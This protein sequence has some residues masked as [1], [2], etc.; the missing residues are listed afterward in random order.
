MPN[1]AGRGRSPGGGG[2]A[3]SRQYRQLSEL[4]DTR[5]SLFWMPM[6]GTG[7]ELWCQSSYKFL[8]GRREDYPNPQQMLGVKSI[9][10]QTGRRAHHKTTPIGL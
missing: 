10:P 2:A 7:Q 9:W 5:I 1:G 8:A 6:V 3:L 4:K